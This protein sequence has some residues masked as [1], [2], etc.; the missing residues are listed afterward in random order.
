MA[1]QWYYEIM[2]TAIGPVTS[3]DLKQKVQQGVILPETP[4]R[5][6]TDGKWQT[7]SRVKGLLDSP[8]VPSPAPPKAT[9]AKGAPG[10]SAT[11]PL[12]AGSG[13][14]TPTVAASS[15]AAPTP[16]AEVTYH[17]AGEQGAAAADE[18]PAEYDFFRFVGFESALGTPLHQALCAYC[19][20]QKVTMTQATRRAIA[21]LVK[22]KDLVDPKP[23]EEV[24][25]AEGLS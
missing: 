18:E 19:Q 17:F 23:V 22:R 12:A 8:E 6:G 1:K 21:E 25:T 15:P 11:I 13:G 7:A 5:M 9:A 14:A 10:K 4:V 2:G 16:H 3:A 20:S 24:A